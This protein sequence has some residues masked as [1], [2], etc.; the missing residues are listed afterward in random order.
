MPI[1]LMNPGEEQAVCA[2]VLQ[3]FDQFEAP[4]QSDLGV[5]EFRGFVQPE[6]MSQRVAAGGFVLVDERPAGITGVIEVRDGNHIALLFVAAAWQGQGI[7]RA[8]MSRACEELK[9][10]VPGVEEL[11]VNAALSARGAYE[12]MGFEAV[13]RAQEV[14]GIRFVPMARRI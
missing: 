6:A 1:R 11:T 8:L 5:R 12:R 9:S 13:D 7:G 14:N 10:R 4:L 3:V 2:F